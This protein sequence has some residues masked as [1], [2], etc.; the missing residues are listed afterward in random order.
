MIADQAVGEDSP[1]DITAFADVELTGDR[2]AP[3]ASAVSS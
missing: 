1:E 2:E 3:V